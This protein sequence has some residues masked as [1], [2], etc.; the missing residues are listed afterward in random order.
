MC[1]VTFRL[2]SQLLKELYVELDTDEKGCVLL[3]AQQLGVYIL[4]GF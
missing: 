3:S 4:V 2:R 1:D